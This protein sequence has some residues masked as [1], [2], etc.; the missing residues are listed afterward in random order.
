MGG[1]RRNVYVHASEDCGTGK[2]GTIL[3]FPG[4]HWHL[5]NVDQSAVM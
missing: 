2:E 1:K 3:L 5:E 4:L